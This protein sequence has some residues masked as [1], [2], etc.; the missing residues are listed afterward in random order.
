[1]SSERARET[2]RQEVAAQ[3]DLIDAEDVEITEADGELRAAI[4]E[5]IKHNAIREKTDGRSDLFDNGEDTE[6]W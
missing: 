5:P 3:S 6:R 1:M 4:P 2:L